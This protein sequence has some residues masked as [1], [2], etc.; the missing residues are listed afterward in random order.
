MD[1]SRLDWS[2][3]L[4]D[5]FSAAQMDRGARSAEP[6]LGAAQQQ[7]RSVGDEFGDEMA[8]RS[9]LKESNG[10][11]LC[12]QNRH[13]WNSRRKAERYRKHRASLAMYHK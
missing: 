9:S 8:L 12:P 3:Q 1:L 2:L 13:P 6:L 7:G 4:P 5:W 11:I 10:I